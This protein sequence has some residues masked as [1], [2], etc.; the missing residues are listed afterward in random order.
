MN[1]ELIELKY[2]AVGMG[3]SLAIWLFVRAWQVEEGPGP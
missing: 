2:V 3:L 1:L